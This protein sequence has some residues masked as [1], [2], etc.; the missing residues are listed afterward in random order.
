[1]AHHETTALVSAVG[2]AEALAQNII[3]LIENDALRER[4]AR[5]GNTFI[6]GMDIN[7]SYHQMKEELTRETPVEAQETAH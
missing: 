5:T 4:I 7:Q 3:R 1:M 6:Q 2:D